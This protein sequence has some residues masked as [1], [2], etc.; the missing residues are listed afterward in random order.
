M[1]T[2]Q[3]PSLTHLAAKEMGNG[4]GIIFSISSTT[5]F[6]LKGGTVP[7]FPKIA[8]FFWPV[9][10]FFPFFC[11]N[12]YYTSLLLIV[13]A[14]RWYV[15]SLYRH[16]FLEDIAKHARVTKKLHFLIGKMTNSKTP[17]ATA[18]KH[19]L[20]LPTSLSCDMAEKR[21]FYREAI[22]SYGD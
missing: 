3:S 4:L 20:W 12:N 9:I 21:N 7:Y 18:P 8:F 10:T 13:C 1:P 17:W 14:L 22:M 15:K 6:V 16:F 2:L 19:V 5:K 11:A